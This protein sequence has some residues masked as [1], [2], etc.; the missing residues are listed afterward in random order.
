M[1]INVYRYNSEDS[2]L[3]H[4]VD[5]T[6][7]NMSTDRVASCRSNF[8]FNYQQLKDHHM[9]GLLGS[10]SNRMMSFDRIFPLN[11]NL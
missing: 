2:A 3:A 7:L 8:C 10:D 4:F 11:D 5:G 6:H 9:P 1:S